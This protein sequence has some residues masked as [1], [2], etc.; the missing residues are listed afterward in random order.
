MAEAIENHQERT[1]G[2]KMT[3]DHSLLNGTHFIA[4]I[5][6]DYHK[7]VEFFGNPSEGDG[8]KMDAEWMILFDDDTVA[9]IYNWKNGHNYLGIDGYAVEDIDLWHIGGHDQQAAENVKKVLNI[10]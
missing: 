8:H 6:V 3:Q 7:L 4:E 10:N 1:T 2:F 5:K 9:T